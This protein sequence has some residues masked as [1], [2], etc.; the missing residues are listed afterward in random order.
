MH[1]G[2]YNLPQAGMEPLGS[3][4][5]GLQPEGRANGSERVNRSARDRGS[6]RVLCTLDHTICPR[7]EWSRW[8]ASDMDFSPKGERT[9]VSESIEVHA[10][11]VPKESHAHSTIQSAPG[12]NGAAGKRATWTSARRASERE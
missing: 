4:R 1:I 9:G 10:I 2:P 5:H 6:Q 12:G 11:E 3:E 8:E 7:R